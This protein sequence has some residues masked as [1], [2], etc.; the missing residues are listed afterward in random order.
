MEIPGRKRCISKMQGLV[1]HKTRSLKGCALSLPS[2][3]EDLV[4]VHCSAR[5][6]CAKKNQYRLTNLGNFL[7]DIF[8]DETHAEITNGSGE[9]D[10]I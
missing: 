7:Q 8:T 2:M 1:C 4:N 5:G 9:Y 6:L 10:S 3:A